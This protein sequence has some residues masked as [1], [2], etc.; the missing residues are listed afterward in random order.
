MPKHYP[1][2]LIH[3]NG[4]YLRLASRQVKRLQIKRR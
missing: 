1:P 3:T 2:P 4:D